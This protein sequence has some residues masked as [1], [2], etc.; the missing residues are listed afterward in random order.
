MIFTAPKMY[1]I[2]SLMALT[3][4]GRT[5]VSVLARGQFFV[6]EKQDAR[7][8]LSSHSPVA[9]AP[10]N[11]AKAV[12]LGPHLQREDF[13]WVQPRYGK[14]SST[15]DEG[16]HKYKG[17]RSSTPLVCCVDVALSSCIKASPREATDQEHG[18]TLPDRSPV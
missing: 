18:N 15:E 14:P 8:V 1:I 3:I 9:N 6:W 13:C 10:A 11:D 5:S 12:S 16:V 7:G 4:Y 17:C 2:F